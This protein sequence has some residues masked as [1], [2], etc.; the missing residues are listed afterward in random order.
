MFSGGGDIVVKIF[1]HDLKR[2]EIIANEM[3]GKISK[4]EGVVSVTSSVRKAIPELR[5]ELDRQRIADLGLSTAQIGQT[6]STSVLGSAVTRYRD[7]GDEYDVR[8]QLEKSARTSKEDLGKYID[9]DANR[10]SDSLAR[11]RDY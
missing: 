11:S 8:L 5:I 10:R 3:E 2:S 1:G 4:I 6:V 7:Q 9:Y